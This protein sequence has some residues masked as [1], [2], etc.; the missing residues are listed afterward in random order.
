MDK[1]TIRII[2]DITLIIVIVG[3]GFYLHTNLNELI[4]DP[5]KEC[6]SNGYQCIRLI[7]GGKYG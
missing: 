4:K 5:C 1:T 6:I 3:F 2:F 7:M